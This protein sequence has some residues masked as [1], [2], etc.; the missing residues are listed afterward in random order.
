MP[1]IILDA[2]G[3]INLYATGRFLP[4]LSELGHDW[5]L[6]AAVLK[7]TKYVR[8]PDPDDPTKLVPVAMALQPAF[9]AGVLKPCNC[10]DDTELELY[11]ELSAK[12]RDDGESM[13]IAIAK[14]RGWQ[15]V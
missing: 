8:Q 14:C 11:V 2:C 6:P 12:I 7:E 10:Q 9:D 15:I 1:A 3:T 5:Y 4:L 13:G